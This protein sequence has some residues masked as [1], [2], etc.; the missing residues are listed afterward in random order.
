MLPALLVYYVLIKVDLSEKA[1]N[2]ILAVLAGLFLSSGIMRFSVVIIGII[3]VGML[4]IRFLDRKPIVLTSYLAFVLAILVANPLMSNRDLGLA[5]ALLAN[6]AGRDIYDFSL[7]LSE[8]VPKDDVVL[9]DSRSKHSGYIQ[10]VSRRDIYALFKAAPSNE[11][12]IGEWY[13]RLQEVKD[14]DQWDANQFSS[15]MQRNNMNFVVINK[16]QY[17]ESFDDMFEKEITSD[18]LILLKRK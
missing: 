3:L 7:S 6:Q 8:I 10:Q 4:I 15:F 11:N 5:N 18:E 13:E 9:A 17:N 2:I 14:V 1:K 16:G 12:G